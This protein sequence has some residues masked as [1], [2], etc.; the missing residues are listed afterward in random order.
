[1]VPGNLFQQGG[2][3]LAGLLQP[4][5][6]GPQ[7]PLLLAHREEIVKKLGSDYSS[8]CLDLEVRK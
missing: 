7:L 1:M 4:V 3:L 2:V 6:Q 5:D 8:V